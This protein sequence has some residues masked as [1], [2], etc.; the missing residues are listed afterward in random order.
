MTGG[1]SWVDLSVIVSTHPGITVHRA[2]LAGT[3]WPK[4]QPNSLLT[5]SVSAQGCCT[6]AESRPKKATNATEAAAR[7]IS[8]QH[9]AE[10]IFNLAVA[11]DEKRSDFARAPTSAKAITRDSQKTTDNNP[12]IVASPLGY[13]ESTITISNIK[14]VFNIEL[15]L[16]KE[17]L[18][19]RNG[20]VAAE[21]LPWS[22]LHFFA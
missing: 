1:M 8:D 9:P 19:V 10:I 21:I 4:I 7:W 6:R 5:T 20:L 17:P 2:P 16:P 3:Y 11:A 15:V 13:L 18:F 14:I 12:A 22:S